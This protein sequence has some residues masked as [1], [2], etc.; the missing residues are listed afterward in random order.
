VTVPALDHEKLLGKL[1]LLRE[2]DA[3]ELKTIANV[4]RPKLFKA[5]QTVVRQGDVADAAFIIVHGRLEA[6]T[7]GGDGKKAVLSVM[8]PSE[9]FGELAVLDGGPRS[10]TVRAMEP[11]LVLAI[12]RSGFEAALKKHPEVAWKISRALA[13]RLR[14]LTERVED[15]TFLEV[16]Q[17][18]AKTLASLAEEHGK[19]GEKGFTILDLALGQR[20]LG[21]MIGATR[22]SVNKTLATFM[23]QGLVAKDGKRLLVR[24]AELR[25]F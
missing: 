25:R 18:L 7:V 20:E 6:S 24:P 3:Y 4:T 10:A 23:K 19:P 1:E 2:L 21:E 17:R 8:G 22:E 11:T 16:P 5:R 14:R 9:V 15:H 13:R 12:E